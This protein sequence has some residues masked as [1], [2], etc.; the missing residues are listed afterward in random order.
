MYKA[1]NKK[2]PK[3]FEIGTIVDDKFNRKNNI[4]RG[5]RK[6]R[7]FDE[8]KEQDAELG[9]SKKKFKDIQLD[10]MK[11]SRNKKWIK[12][13]RSVLKGGEKFKKLKMN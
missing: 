6:A 1:E 13:K 10:K 3:Y 11:N 9:Y 5:E 2:L 8:F 4:K 12:L 7:L